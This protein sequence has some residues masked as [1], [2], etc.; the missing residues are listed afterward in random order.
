M[1]RRIKSKDEEKGEEG[2]CGEEKQLRGRMRS[3]EEKI[4]TEDDVKYE[5]ENEEKEL[6]TMMR[7]GMKIE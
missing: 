2:G 1:R 6:R 5:E 7:R 4:K 3:D